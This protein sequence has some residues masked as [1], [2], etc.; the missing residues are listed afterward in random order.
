MKTYNNL[1]G[2][3]ISPENLFISWERFK[4]GKRDKPDVMEFEYELEKNI[5]DLH[6]DLKEK[7]YKHGPY[8]GFYIRDPKVRHIHK[9]TV[10]DRVVHHAVFKVLNLVYEPTLIPTSFSCRIGKGNHKGVR[11]LDQMLRK[12]SRNYTKSCF[13][14]K[15][16]V[17]KFFDSIDHEV[18]LEILRQRIRDEDVFSLLKEIIGSFS[19]SHLNLFHRRGLPIGNL[20]SQLFANV[21]MNELDQFVKHELKIKYYARYT[22][23]FVILSDV[24]DFNEILLQI[25]QFLKDRLC[26]KL[27]PSKVS[28]RK[29]RQ[30][31][32]FLGYVIRHHHK[33]P[34]TKTRKRMWRKLKGRAKEHKKGD[35]DDE[36]LEQSLNSYLGLLS[37][38]NAHR[39][40]ERLKNDLWF[41]MNE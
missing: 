14:L 5:F 29:L 11:V 13:A 9:A 7:T 33:L 22:D 35:I 32:D 25:K 20:T 34:R 30:G 37:H 21:Y 27:H 15:C 36:S 39:L 38:A 26:L 31:V 3:I 41:W 4:K 16:D 24:D 8:K 10:R 2:L 1:Y 18:L 40:S 28:V 23:D 19:A 6:R 12:A 17:K